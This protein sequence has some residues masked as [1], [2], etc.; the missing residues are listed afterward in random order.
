MSFPAI[1]WTKPP[2]AAAGTAVERSE[3]S[4]AA[5][6][7]ILPVPERICEGVFWK[8]ELLPDP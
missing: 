1:M 8:I 2:V 7:T 4:K 5:A 3:T 6:K